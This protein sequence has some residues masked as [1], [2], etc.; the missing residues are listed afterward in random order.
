MED[1]ERVY[2]EQISPLMAQIIQI[3]QDNGMPL[4]AHVQY[5]PEGLATTSVGTTAE[6]M[7]KMRIAAQ[8]AHCI[9]ASNLDE[10]LFWLVKEEARQ[11][12]GSLMLAALQ[13][14]RALQT[15]AKT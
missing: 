12:T 15:S 1:K 5:S 13:V 8:L 7:L 3:C 4:V 9:V 11:S 10:F 6:S 14:T 2:D